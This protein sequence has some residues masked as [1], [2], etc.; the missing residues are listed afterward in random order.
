MRKK[1]TS[2]QRIFVGDI[3]VTKKTFEPIDESKRK[4]RLDGKQ[5]RGMV[6][7]TREHQGKR[8]FGVRLSKGLVFT[9]TL[10]GLLSGTQGFWM[11]PEDLELD[12]E[13]ADI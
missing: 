4:H 1:E 13:C 6:V 7:A 5:Y 9:N 8:Q 12:S 2:N 10:N 3:I 11:D